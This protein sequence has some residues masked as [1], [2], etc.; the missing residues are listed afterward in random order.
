MKKSLSKKIIIIFIKLLVGVLS[1]WLIYHRLHQIP[2]F[3]EECLRLFNSAQTL[4]IL[5]LVLLMM[6]INWGIESF[7][8]QLITKSTEHISFKTAIKSVF[9]GICLGNLAP[10][11]AMEFLAKIYFFKPQNKP[12]VTV[13]HFINGMF[14]MLITVTMGIIAVALKANENKQH[15]TVVYLMIFGGI[16]L[17]MG[18]CLAILNVGFIQKKL[19]FLKWFNTLKEGNVVSFSKTLLASLISLS[20]IRYVVFTTQFYLIYS[21]FTPAV[22]VTQT[23][24]GIAAYFMLTSIIPMISVIEPAIRAAI[25]LFVFNNVADNSV[26][27]VLSSTFLWLIN[28]IVPSFLGYLIILRQKIDIKSFSLKQSNDD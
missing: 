17:I 3:K 10:G 27:I 15:T 24:I 4:Y 21:A 1:F 23:F 2:N 12:T 13:L 5:G 25:A 20:I 9:S 6:P 11:R 22:S 19:T 14:Q 18:F 7:K 8:W 16:L 26:T 28:V